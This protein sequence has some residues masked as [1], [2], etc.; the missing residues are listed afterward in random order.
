MPAPPARGAGAHGTGTVNPADLSSV[1]VNILDCTLWQRQ[2]GA[3]S[4]EIV[5]ALVCQV[6]APAAT[7]AG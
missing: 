6:S 1:L 2:L 3:I 4:E 5:A 7:V